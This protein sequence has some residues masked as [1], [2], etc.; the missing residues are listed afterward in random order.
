MILIDLIRLGPLTDLTTGDLRVKVG[1]IDGPILKE[2]PQLSDAKLVE[3]TP[4]GHAS[5]KRHDS[6]ACQHG[7][8]VVGILA[9]KRNSS[10]IGICP[11]CTFLLRPI[12]LEA[13]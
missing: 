10:A 12:F 13:A 1:V 4:R 8:F 9:G 3:I 7:T 2:H 6:L 11:G 5:C